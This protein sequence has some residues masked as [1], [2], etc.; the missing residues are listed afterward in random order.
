M[1]IASL[2]SPTETQIPGTTLKLTCKQS[3]LARGLSLV[4]H[5]CLS[6]S[7]KPILSCL[8]LSTDQGRLRISATNLEI[9]IQVWVDAQIE[10]EGTTALP[11]EILTK[12]VA[13]MPKESLTL[14]IAPGSQT[15]HIECAGSVSNIRGQDPRD[16]PVIPGID[17]DQQTC[18]ISAG[19]LK[20]MIEQT[21]FAA[22]TNLATPVMTAV[23]TQIDEKT[24]TFAAATSL[25]L[26]ERIAPL[27]KSGTPLPPV[28]IPARNLMELARILPSQGDVQ[29]V[30]TPQQNQVVFHCE[31]GERIDFVSRLISGTFPPYQRFIPK[32]FTTRCVVE[33]KQFVAALM[34]A[35]VFAKDEFKT[36][37]VTLKL[38]DTGSGSLM[39]EADDADTGDHVSA[40]GARVTGPERRIIIPLRYLLEAL[41]GIDT[42]EVVFSVIELGRP[43]VLKPQSDVQYTSMVMSAQDNKTR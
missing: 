2:A 36:A 24:L 25:R 6:N 30:V 20:R 33:T 19:L 15:L 34:R 10:G 1:A 38:S 13:L 5:A 35:S 9:G 43:T 14:S 41:E 29:I 3:D 21:A 28:L 37:R 16:F 17:G 26:A 40:V 18:G 42:P 8:L 31:Q 4:S 7:T 32:E 11:A 23:F 27:P 22:E 39:V 12:M